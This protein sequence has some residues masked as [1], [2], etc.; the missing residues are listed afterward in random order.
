MVE[1]CLNRSPHFLSAVLGVFK[2]AAY[3]GPMGDDPY[4]GVYIAP[5]RPKEVTVDCWD[6][7]RQRFLGHWN[8]GGKLMESGLHGQ[9]R[10]PVRLADMEA[11]D[12]DF[13]GAWLAALHEGRVRPP[14]STDEDADE[15]E[16]EEEDE[17]EG[18]EAEVEGEEGEVEGEE[19][20]EEGE[21]ADEEG[22]EAEE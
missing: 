9:P 1:R 21:E 16:D 4:D 11:K 20:D 7:V 12:A 22:E 17:V 8:A 13:R 10:F 3:G 5:P 15:E 2:V 19:A 14:A 6:V 18:E